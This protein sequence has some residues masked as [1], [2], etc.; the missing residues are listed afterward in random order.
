MNGKK[1]RRLDKSIYCLMDLTTDAHID[2]MIALEKGKIS[3]KMTVIRKRHE[4]SLKMTV[5][6]VRSEDGH[7]HYVQS[8]NQEEIKIYTIKKKSLDPC[9][10]KLK[11]SPCNA[12]VHTYS[13]NCVD[14]LIKNNL[15]KHIHYIL[16]DNPKIPISMN[17][18]PT[19]LVIEEDVER[20]EE[21]SFHQS[22]MKR[23]QDSRAL[24]DI[25]SDLIKDL[26]SLICST[27]QFSEQQIKFVRQEVR[28]IRNVCLSME[29]GDPLSKPE[30]EDPFD[31]KR[32]LCKQIR[33]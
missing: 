32:N 5:T 13:C 20:T 3:N 31:K 9:P 22:Q 27:A 33:F 2:R 11:C 10:C 28:K 18:E 19:E 29:S 25:R 16:A 24:E 17:I 1:V 8:E 23:S 26:D 12:C 30:V 7:E 4:H 14:Y 6:K 15:C 21:M